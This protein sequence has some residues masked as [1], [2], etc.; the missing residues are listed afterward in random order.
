MTLPF[1]EP[2]QT[3]VEEQVFEREDRDSTFIISGNR[4][5]LALLV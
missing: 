4:F 3:S 5:P 2:A 1:N